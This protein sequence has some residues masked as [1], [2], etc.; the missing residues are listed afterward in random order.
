MVPAGRILLL[1]S[2]L[3]QRRLLSNRSQ[4][5]L[6]GEGPHENAMGPVDYA[7]A[8]ATP[9]FLHRLPFQVYDGSDTELKKPLGEVAKVCTPPLN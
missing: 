9:R 7:A 8:K 3:L 2:V 1:A 6:R 4:C 5:A